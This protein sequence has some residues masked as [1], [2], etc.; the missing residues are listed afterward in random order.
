MVDPSW[1]G[2][3]DARLHQALLQAG[4]QVHSLIQSLYNPVVTQSKMQ[5]NSIDR[6]I[7]D[8]LASMRGHIRDLEL[9]SEEQETW[10]NVGFRSDDVPPCPTRHAWHQP[11]DEEAEAVEACLRAH[12]ADYERYSE[13]CK[14]PRPSLCADSRLLRF[15][16]EDSAL[17]CCHV[18]RTANGRPCQQLSSCRCRGRRPNSPSR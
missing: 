7:K 5:L 6:Q 10:V 14:A 1:L 4:S 2:S 18:Y 8:L 3:E 9:S 11:R 16:H 13:G 15:M 12:K 17:Y